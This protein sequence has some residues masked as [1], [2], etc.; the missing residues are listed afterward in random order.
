MTL[1][2]AL[3]HHVET[4]RENVAFIRSTVSFDIAPRRPA[5]REGFAASEA[6]WQELSEPVGFAAQ[7]ATMSPVTLKV[8]LC[9]QYRPI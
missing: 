5:D 3:Y 9:P 2:G 6:K 7:I 8:R 1:I 4:G